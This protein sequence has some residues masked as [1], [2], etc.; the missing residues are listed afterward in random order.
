MPVPKEASPQIAVEKPVEMLLP[1]LRLPR[2]AVLLIRPLNV[3]VMESRCCGEA[4]VAVYGS[5]NDS[6]L[7]SFQLSEK[8]QK[9]L[10]EVSKTSNPTAGSWIDARSLDVTLGTST[11]FSVEETSRM[12]LGW[13][14]VPEVLM[15]TFW[16]EM[17]R[18]RRVKMQKGRRAERRKGRA[19]SYIVGAGRR[20]RLL[21]PLNAW[22]G[23]YVRL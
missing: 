5:E 14:G 15:A 2:M 19:L 6:S 11:P 3:F 18:D 1:S 4:A 12:A 9:L 17:Q 23:Q 10:V 8:Y 7:I 13:A 22:L 16:A 21:L 20:Q